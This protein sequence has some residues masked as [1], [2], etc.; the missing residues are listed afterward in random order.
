MNK[1]TKE[2]ADKIY[3]VGFRNGQ[4]AMR[5]KILKKINRDWSLVATKKPMDLI[6]K[7]MKIIDKISIS[8]SQ[9]PNA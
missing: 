1:E 4:I 2:I 6:M 7:I 8:K 5:S 9:L 3:A